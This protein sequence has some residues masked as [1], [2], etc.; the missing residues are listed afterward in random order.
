MIRLHVHVRLHAARSPGL[1]VLRA[2]MGRLCISRSKYGSRHRASDVRM[3]RVPAATGW[4]EMSK[5]DNPHRRHQHHD[6]AA[7]RHGLFRLHLAARHRRRRATLLR[8]TDDV[9]SM[10]A[11]D[12][13]FGHSDD[14]R[15]VGGQGRRPAAHLRLCVLQ[16]RAGPTGCSITPPCSWARRRR[17]T[18]RTPP[19]ARAS[20]AA[21]P[22]GRGRRRAISRAG[23]ARSSSR[24]RYLGWF[25]GPWTLR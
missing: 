24:S 23:S 19:R 10:F 3:T 14:A 22:H 21:R 1:L 4:R 25:L 11:D 17:R 12:L 2:R 6:L 13:P 16:V 8:S 5:R 15:A 9:L 18:R 7:E 20:P